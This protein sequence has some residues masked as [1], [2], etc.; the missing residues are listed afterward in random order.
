MCTAAIFI[1]SSKIKVR[2]GMT[3]QLNCC[4][5]PLTTDKDIGGK[6]LEMLLQSWPP[7]M[8]NIFNII[9]GF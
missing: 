7:C 3:K 6:G 9:K 2:Q 5:L 1:T 4:F 8:L